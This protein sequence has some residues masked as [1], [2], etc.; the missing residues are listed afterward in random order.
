MLP[1]GLLHFVKTGHYY[2]LFKFKFNTFFLVFGGTISKDFVRIQFTA[3][4]F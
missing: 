1:E 4:Y 2:Y 3:Y